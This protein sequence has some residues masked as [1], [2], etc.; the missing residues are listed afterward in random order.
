MEN[1]N[2]NNQQPNWQQAL[3]EFSDQ[4]EQQAQPQQFAQQAQ[5][6][7]FAQQAQPQQ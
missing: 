3:N 5:P 7:Q 6:Q 2:T 4:P 1:N